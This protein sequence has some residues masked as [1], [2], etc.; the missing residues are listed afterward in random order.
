MWAFAHRNGI[1]KKAYLLYFSEDV[2]N[3]TK[4]S[5][6]KY[7]ARFSLSS[8]GHL[9]FTEMPWWSL[10]CAHLSVMLISWAL[11]A[12]VQGWEASVPGQPL[13]MSP[14]YSNPRFCFRRHPFAFGVHLIPAHSRH[15][16]DL[17]VLLS[18]WLLS[19][20]RRGV[21]IALTQVLCPTSMSPAPASQWSILCHFSEHITDQGK[22]L[23]IV[24]FCRQS[25]FITALA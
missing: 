24:E 14:N 1:F 7:Q 18:L 12:S 5:L 13:Q 6:N 4:R 8:P 9:I 22:G 17:G 16:W 25:E 15:A 19:V 11:A 2:F 10:S 21:C 20:S 3:W 23:F